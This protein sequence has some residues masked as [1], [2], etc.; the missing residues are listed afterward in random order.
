MSA[1]VAAETSSQIVLRNKAYYLHTYIHNKFGSI[2]YSHIS[3]YILASFKYQKL[4][5]GNDIKGIYIFI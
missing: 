5:C 4:I 1:I 3:E 2:I